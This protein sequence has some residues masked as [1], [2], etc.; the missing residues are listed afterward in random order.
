MTDMRWAISGAD[1]HDDITFTDGRL[2]GPDLV[3]LEVEALTVGKRL[4]V[5]RSPNPIYEAG[6]DTP[7][8]AWATITEAA[9]R[10]YGP[11]A[12]E[13]PRAPDPA[14]YKPLPPGAIA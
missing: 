13:A 1:D 11:E 14:F 4:V 10:L 12:V 9:R 6:L 8:Q 5:P 3:L 7:M 2:A